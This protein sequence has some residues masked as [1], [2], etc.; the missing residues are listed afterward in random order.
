MMRLLPSSDE[1]RCNKQLLVDCPSTS[2]PCSKINKPTTLGAGATGAL[3]ETLDRK[4]VPVITCRAGQGYCS[5]SV[6]M[7]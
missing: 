1:G 3:S 2:R 5:F 4:K 7:L 6:P